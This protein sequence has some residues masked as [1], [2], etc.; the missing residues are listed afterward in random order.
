MYS[1]ALLL[2][3][4]IGVAGCRPRIPF[5]VIE[6][7]TAH[8]I[9]VTYVEHAAQGDA[10]RTDPRRCIATSTAPVVL[11]TDEIDLYIARGYI[12]PS[13]GVEIDTANCEVHL[14]IGPGFSGAFQPGPFCADSAESPDTVRRYE[15]T[16]DYLSIES[17]AGKME[18]R[19]WDTA[20]QF[21]RAR[22]WC[23]LRV[24]ESR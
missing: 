8:A 10:P 18:W 6:N 23:V 3:A 12:V 20:R 15:P 9:R 14:D 1:R 11:P 17:A 5:L 16:L 4:L 13:A 19:G 2:A 7:D 22:Y 21:E 24:S